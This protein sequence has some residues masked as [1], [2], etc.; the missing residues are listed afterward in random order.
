MKIKE[1]QEMEKYL[2]DPRDRKSPEERAKI[3]RTKTVEDA[4]RV[5]AKRKEYGL[6]DMQKH[7]INMINKFE[8]GPDIKEEDLFVKAIRN[9]STPVPGFVGGATPND[10]PTHAERIASNKQLEKYA[11][12][13]DSKGAWKKFVKANETKPY[14]LQNLGTGELENV[15]A[16]DWKPKKDKNGYLVE[17]TPKMVGELAER[18]EKS[19]QMSGSDGRYDKPMTH[20]EVSRKVFK[21]KRSFEPKKKIPIAA[22]APVP[23][24]TY[25]QYEPLPQI[26]ID[27]ET[28]RLAANFRKLVKENED[29]KERNKY[30]G[31]AGLMGEE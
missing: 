8:D 30:A 3:I 6:P 23:M 13:P 31:L 10:R 11:T 27:P 14:Y 1:Y 7:A 12:Q 29:E 18:L 20:R 5:A 17:A 16:A 2:T 19:R 24:S 9:S 22:A 28:E 25:S 4:K 26:V 15:N 21:D